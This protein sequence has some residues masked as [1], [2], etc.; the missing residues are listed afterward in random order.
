MEKVVLDYINIIVKSPVFSGK[1]TLDSALLLVKKIDTKNVLQNFGEETILNY[2]E[3]IKPA[4]E[5]YYYDGFYFLKEFNFNKFKCLQQVVQE[6]DY[7]NLTTINKKIQY[8]VNFFII[9][10][11]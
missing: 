4:I 3:Q 1:Y 2:K 7:F 10:L 5:K 8:N 9:F 6:K 11:T